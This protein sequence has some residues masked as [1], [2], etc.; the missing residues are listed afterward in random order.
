MS[1]TIRARFDIN[2][3]AAWPIAFVIAVLL[4]A[5]NGVLARVYLQQLHRASAGADRALQV[6]LVLKQIEDLAE[7]CGWDQRNYRLSGD[8]QYLGSYRK[9]EMELPAQLAQL[10]SLVAHDNKQFERFEGLKT[11]IEQDRTE[12]AAT[13]APIE[14][15]FSD[16]HLPSELAASVDRTMAISAAVDAMLENE[17]SLLRDNLATIESHSAIAL[18][19]GMLVRTGIIGLVVVVI[20]MMYRKARSNQE[21]ATVQSSALRESE[22]RSAG[23]SRRALSASCWGSRTQGASCRR[24]RRFVGCSAS[25]LNSSSAAPSWT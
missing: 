16:G 17:R 20:A 18:G 13:L 5:A 11:L 1:G 23:S 3:R 21:L 4:I 25:N 7:A 2:G 19:T 8:A 15:R 12:L 6:M 9:A 22:Q 10:R 14:T 24:T